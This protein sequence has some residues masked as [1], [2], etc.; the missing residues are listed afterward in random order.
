MKSKE[1]KNPCGGLFLPQ[2]SSIYNSLMFSRFF[3]E[4]DKAVMG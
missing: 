4:N 1:E 2:A 3:E